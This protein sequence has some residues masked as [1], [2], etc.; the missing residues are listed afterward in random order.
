MFLGA[1]AALAG[2]GALHV[3][4]DFLLAL[5][6][7]VIPVLLLLLVLLLVSCHVSILLSACL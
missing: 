6:V 3:V 1:A 7:L 2:A 5:V 4:L